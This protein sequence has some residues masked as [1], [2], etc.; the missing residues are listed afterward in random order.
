MTCTAGGCSQQFQYGALGWT[1][2]NGTRLTDGAI[3][4]LWIL[5]GGGS[6]PLGYPTGNLSC[7]LANGGCRQTFQNG[8]IYWSA[9]TGAHSLS[10]DIATAWTGMGGEGGEPRLPGRRAAADLRGDR[11]GLPG[12][13]AD[14]RHGVPDGD[15]VLTGCGR[16]DVGRTRR[17]LSRHRRHGTP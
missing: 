10:G 1:A 14:L 15:P 12:R 7:G 9:A 6:G 13:P 8:T 5:Q 3:G 16:G 17:H 4:G 11:P 2:A